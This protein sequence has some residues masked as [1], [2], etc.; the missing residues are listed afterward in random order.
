[1][2]QRGFNE[3]VLTTGLL[4]LGLYFSVL[5]ARGT[6][7]YL[8]FRRLRPSAL[9]TWAAPRPAHFKSLVALGVVS[10]LVAALNSYMDRP[11]HHVVPQGLM[12]LY[13]VLMVPVMA[14]IPL[15]L[16]ED[17]VWAESGF[18]SWDEI[19]R[20]AFRESPEIV[21]ILLPRTGT[22]SFRLRV[23]PGEYGAVR[24]TLEDKM[25]EHVLQVD[26]GMLGL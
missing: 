9:V 25:R 24:K 21:L 18:L 23:P 16:Y 17:G 6:A 2:D 1:M 7:L 14:S 15:G 10:A 12:S 8:R 13:F 19:G 22:S 4:A 26:R 11:I 5:L 3:T 20:M